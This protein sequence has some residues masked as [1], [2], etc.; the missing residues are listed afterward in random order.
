MG[1]FFEF[2]LA[3]RLVFSGMPILQDPIYLAA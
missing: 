1:K 3:A 2:A